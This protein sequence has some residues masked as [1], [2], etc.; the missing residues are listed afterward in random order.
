LAAYT[1]HAVTLVAPQKEGLALMQKSLRVRFWVETVLAAVTG[2]LFV[3]TLLVRDW[4]E[5]V[6][7][8]EPDQHNGALE[9]A[10]VGALLI[11]TVAWSVL[12]RAEW[13][14]AVRVVA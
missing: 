5:V 4:V 11:A 9:W 14:R 6:F 12:A 1:P 8:V 2:V 13:K 3:V 10:I 7:G